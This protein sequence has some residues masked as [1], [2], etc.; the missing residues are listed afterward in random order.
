MLLRK[1]D[2]S[3]LIVNPNNDRHGDLKD[4]NGA[5]HWLL[6][7]KTDHMK[8]LAQDIIAQGQVYEPPLVSSEGDKFLVFDG[9][10][11]V[12]CLKAFDNPTLAIKPEL[13]KFFA[14]LAGSADVPFW[15]KVECQIEADRDRIDEILFR[16][17]TGTQGGVGQFS[18][19]DIAKTNFVNRT[20]KHQ[21]LN[22]AELVEGALAAAN[23]HPAPGAIPR[24]NLNRLLSGESTR[25]RVGL[26]VKNNELYFT[27]DPG[28]VI[29]ALSAIADDL[30]EQEIV[31]GD[32]WDNNAKHRYLDRLEHSCRLPTP[33]QILTA[34]QPFIS[35]A[36][37]SHKSKPPARA[38]AAQK[39]SQPLPPRETLIP[40]S[41]NYGVLWS[42]ETQRIRHIWDE[43]Q[44]QLRFDRHK[45]AIAVLTRVLIELSTDYCIKQLAIQG[46]HP[47]DKL[48]M[49][50]EKTAKHLRSISMIDDKY[51]GEI[52]K[53]GNSDA[54]VSS[55]TMNRYVHSNTFNPSP[56]HISA[57]WDTFSTYVVKCL[58]S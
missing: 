25:N 32:L 45:N 8:K 41:I 34:P 29:E 42:H 27:H 13:Q 20:G 26:S 57:I 11:R 43:L 35:T 46:V 54:I 40:S 2:L 12:C 55:D 3:S 24:S 53:I 18:W 14:E 9:N 47:N 16:R 49:K 50:I 6:S 19:D 17:H 1:I 23:N 30:I 31:L 48:A 4:E 52:K 36:R 21:A 7:Q 58:N 51:L 5:I 44:F 37:A 33:R 56:A 22:I 10:R 15:R 38:S 39:L 28:A